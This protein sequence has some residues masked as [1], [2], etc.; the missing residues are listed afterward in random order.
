MKS[1]AIAIAF[2]LMIVLA[3]AAVPQSAPRVTYVVE[4][5]PF[6]VWLSNL[7]RAGAWIVGSLCYMPLGILLA[8]IFDD[9]Q[10]WLRWTNYV[11]RQFAPTKHFVMP[12]Y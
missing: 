10:T 3:C 5:L 11:V 8:I 9:G 6:V 12:T 4:E 2:A 7:T 1:S